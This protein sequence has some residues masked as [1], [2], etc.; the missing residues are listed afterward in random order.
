M[1]IKCQELYSHVVIIAVGWLLSFIC[2]SISV[3]SRTM[4]LLISVLRPIWWCRNTTQNIISKNTE[5]Q[6]TSLKGIL[7]KELNSLT[8]AP[9]TILAFLLIL[10][11]ILLPLNL[12]LLFLNS[13]TNWLFP[14]LSNLN[15]HSFSH[16]LALPI[17][18]FSLE[19][20]RGKAVKTCGRN[21]SLEA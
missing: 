2:I 20:R 15:Q 21:K 9:E 7:K 19:D 18:E 5:M 11:H 12:L 13:S 1:N 6:W 16:H 3:R 17:P 14:I 8:H 10:S 4:S